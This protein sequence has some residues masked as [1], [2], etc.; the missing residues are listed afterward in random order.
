MLHNKILHKH[1]YRN[2]KKG[3]RIFIGENKHPA[4]QPPPYSNDYI[5]Y[6]RVYMRR[7]FRCYNVS[8]MRCTRSKNNNKKPKITGRKKLWRIQ[9]EKRAFELSWKSKQRVLAICSAYPS[10]AKGERKINAAVSLRAYDAAEEYRNKICHPV[11]G[12]SRARPKFFIPRNAQQ[13]R[14]VINTAKHTVNLLRFIRSIV[15]LYHFLNFITL[16]FLSTCSPFVSFS[17]VQCII[18]CYICDQWFPNGLRL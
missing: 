18:L 16:A 8:L 17:C 4:M 14:N 11:N 1:A 3:R 6:T 12:N 9:R 15:L 10:T 2:R 7:Q 5:N 13:Q